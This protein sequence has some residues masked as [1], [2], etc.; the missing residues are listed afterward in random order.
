MSRSVIRATAG[1]LCTLLLLLA[2]QAATTSVSASSCTVTVTAPESIQEAIEAAGPGDV[3]CLSGVFHQSVVLAAEHSGITLRAAPD[4]EAVLDGGGEADPGTV[5]SPNYAILLEDGTSDV[6]IEGL[7]I[8]NYAGEGGTGQG[9][10]IQAWGVSTSDITVQGNYLHDNAWN[11]LLVGSEGDAFH[12]GWVVEDNIAADNSFVALELTNCNGCVV[13]ENIVSGG[14]VGI[15]V[16]ARNT[17]PESGQIQMDDVLVEENEV[18]GSSIGIYIL[19]LASE[20]LPPFEPIEDANALLMD[21]E[22]KENSVDESLIGIYLL[23][24]LGGTLTDVTVEENSVLDSAFYG[25]LSHGLQDGEIAENEVSASGL[26]GIALS[27]RF[28][29]QT[30]TSHPSNDNEVSEN[31]VEDSGRYGI[32]VT[33]GSSRNVLS[34]NVITDSGTADIFDDGTGEDNVY[35]ENECATSLPEGL[36]G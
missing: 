24:F 27:Q 16:Q 7:E 12:E 28:D 5:L 18:T 6:T 25:I 14:I 1:I 2:V 30:A 31:V 9:N 19:S 21:V 15:L 3:I 29:G 8:R 36:C 11:G 32:S 33:S 26:D 13:K 4:A 20:P 35:E 22:V 34:E 23:G 10:A 17:I